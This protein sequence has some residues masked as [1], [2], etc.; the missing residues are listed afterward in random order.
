M[1]EVSYPVPL[2]LIL[3]LPQGL[4]LLMSV[5]LLLT[6]APLSLGTFRQPVFQLQSDFQAQKRSLTAPCPCYCG[7]TLLPSLA[8]A[9]S[10]MPAWQ[11]SPGYPV[12]ELFS[13]YPFHV[14]PVLWQTLEDSV[15]RSPCLKPLQTCHTHG[16]LLLTHFSVEHN[17]ILF[18][19]LYVYSEH[20]SQ[21]T[22]SCLSFIFATKQ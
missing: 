11:N 2:S 21:R 6:L 8:W 10:Y 4:P 17:L 1:S 15:Q 3:M 12:S 20:L 14:S 16:L 18:I 13:R 7:C 9:V 19:L 5:S 22:P